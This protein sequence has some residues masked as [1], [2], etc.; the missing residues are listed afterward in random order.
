[1]GSRLEMNPAGIEPLGSLRGEM[2]PLLAPLQFTRR[3]GIAAPRLS[4]PGAVAWSRRRGRCTLFAPRLPPPNSTCRLD[5]TTAEGK[6]SFRHPQGVAHRFGTWVSGRRLA[7]A[8]PF[9]VA[10][11]VIVSH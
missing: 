11:P 4:L 1:M 5:R 8:T 7:A 10:A 3:P 9:E 6:S 2:T